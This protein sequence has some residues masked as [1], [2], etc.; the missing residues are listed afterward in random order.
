MT[1]T[2]RM[3]SL[4]S[5]ALLTTAIAGCQS[6]LPTLDSAEVEARVPGDVD[7]RVEERPAESVDAGEN[8]VRVLTLPEAVRRAVLHDPRLQS[9]LAHVRIAEADAVQS[10]LLPNTVLSV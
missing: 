6:A 5:G 3:F 4:C 2:S 7:V 1:F 10:M 9:A 8:D